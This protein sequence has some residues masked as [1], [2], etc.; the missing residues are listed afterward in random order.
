MERPDPLAEPEGYGGRHTEALAMAQHVRPP[1][2]FLQRMMGCPPPVWLNRDEEKRPD[3]FCTQY[4]GAIRCPAPATHREWI[5]CQTG[6]HIDKSDL[7]P[8]HA[9]LL[10]GLVLHCKRCWDKTGEVSNAR[11]IKTEVIQEGSELCEKSSAPAR[12]RSPAASG[13]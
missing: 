9:R 4:S 11:V 7:C 6:E 13:A 1:G 8:M 5:G 3:G 10:A 12:S 2:D